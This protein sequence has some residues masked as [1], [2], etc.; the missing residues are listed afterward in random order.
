[1]SFSRSFLKN[2]LSLQSHTVQEPAVSPANGD[3][4]KR[5]NFLKINLLILFIYLFLAA[6]G[7]CCCTWAFSTCSEQGLLF[8]AVRGLLIA[9]ASLVA[10]HGLQAHGLQQLWL[11]G[12]RA[13][14]QQLQCTGLVALRHVGS[15]QTRAR[16]CVPCIGRQILNQCAIRETQKDTI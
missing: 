7:L 12:S 1:M 15:S 6:L 8:I 2:Q 5:Y 14:D 11:S 9:V 16:T 4:L 10:E 13:Q 3:T